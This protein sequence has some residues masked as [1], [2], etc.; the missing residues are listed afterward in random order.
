MSEYTV[1]E[2]HLIGFVPGTGLV[3]SVPLAEVGLALS[4][5]GLVRRLT[6][7]DVD[8]LAGMDFDEVI[9]GDDVGVDI[10]DEIGW[11]APKGLKKL[12]K[13]ARKVVDNKLTRGVVKIASKV[14]PAPYNVA[15]KAAQAGLN[16]GK[17]RRKG[18]KR[19]I[20]ITPVVQALA[21]GK[22]SPE[23][24]TRAAESIGLTGD[25]VLSAAALGKIQIAAAG[26]DRKAAATAEVIEAIDQA[27][28]GDT[29]KAVGVITQLDTQSRYPG[30]RTFV[31]RAPDGKDYQAIIIPG[32]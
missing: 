22:I 6:A 18:D 4:R 26:G 21:Q 29:R 15:V 20:K 28:Q 30:A 13:I 31:V 2:G 8:E 19:A 23:Q 10:G 12:G 5:R 3:A 7:S 9:G 11:R 14:V 27:E 16:L 32:Q 24:A 25:E 17:K 1:T